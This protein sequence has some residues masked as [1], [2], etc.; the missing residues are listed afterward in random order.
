MRLV[1]LDRHVAQQ[2][3]IVV[4]VRLF[5][6]RCVSLVSDGRFVQGDVC[7]PP[8]SDFVLSALHMHRR[9]RNLAMY[10]LPTEMDMLVVARSVKHVWILLVVLQ[11]PISSVLGRHSVAVCALCS[12][13]IPPK[14]MCF[15]P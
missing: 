11:K 9:F 2:E 3:E 8:G 1:P 7:C 4:K 15:L 12:L 14:L 6:G 13:V 5:Y 10:A